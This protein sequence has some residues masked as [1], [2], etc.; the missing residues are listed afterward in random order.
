MINYRKSKIYMITSKKNN[1]IYIGSTTYPLEHRLLGH[2]DDYERWL[3]GKHGYVSSYQL[4]L[5][6]NGEKQ[7]I[8]LENYPCYTKEELHER[9]TYW[10]KK[11]RII[12]VNIHLPITKR[13]IADIYRKTSSKKFINTIDFID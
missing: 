11:Y 12:C 2:K 6:G 13:K 8:L 5:P 1:K 9:E 3:N 4:L 10:I 7:I